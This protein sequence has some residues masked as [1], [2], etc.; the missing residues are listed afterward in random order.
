[1]G[2]NIIESHGSVV[3]AFVI[4][5][6]WNWLAPHME[7]CVGLDFHFGVRSI[8]NACLKLSPFTNFIVMQMETRS[9]K[10]PEISP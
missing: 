2:R 10:C 4:M 8:V 7:Y 5:A 9:L 1:M 3:Q 6:D